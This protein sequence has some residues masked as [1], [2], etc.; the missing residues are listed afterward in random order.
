MGSTH[1]SNGQRSGPRRGG[2]RRS[3]RRAAAVL[4]GHARQRLD[5][6]RLV[7]RLSL[8]ALRPPKVVGGENWALRCGQIYSTIVVG[9][10]RRRVIDLLPDRQ[11]Q[12]LSNWLRTRPTIEVVARDSLDRRCPQH[13]D[14]S[15]PGDAACGGLI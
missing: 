9:N 2:P 6:L 3:S 5:F 7:R 15:A 4:L 1:A 14:D 11:G 8:P 10:E 13:L 12:T